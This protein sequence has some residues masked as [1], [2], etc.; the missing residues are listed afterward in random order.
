MFSYFLFLI[1][2]FKILKILY[3]NNY[4]IIIHNNRNASICSRLALFFYIKKINS[5][6]L[7]RGMYFHDNQNFLKKIISFS[8]EIFLLISTNVVLSQTKEDL[9]KM[10]FFL[11][12]FKIKFHYIGNGIDTKKFRPITTKNFFLFTTTCRIT[13]GKGLEILLSAFEKLLK[14]KKDIKLIIIGGPL[15][16]IDKIYFKK[17][18][19][20]FSK[21]FMT[22]IVRITGLVKKVSFYVNRSRFYVHPSFREGL[23]R[24]LLEAMSSGN[25]PIASNIRGSREVIK[26]NVNGF[27]YNPYN[28]EDLYQTLLN[29]LNMPKSKIN[30]LKFKATN[31]V[32]NKYY[33]KKYLSNQ[34][35]YIK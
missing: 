8:I 26:H 20:K 23:S 22:K 30:L 35:V 15:T 34:L 17:L 9:K 19:N 11:K 1:T 13:E 6:Y 28:P 24:S 2:P 25:I 18:K 33:L 32:H 10:Y 14:V 12:F 21:L 7:A 5:V 31:T 3:K 16:D 4:D 27:L 29:V